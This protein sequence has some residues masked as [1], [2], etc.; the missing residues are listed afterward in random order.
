MIEI[1]GMAAHWIAKEL[2]DDYLWPELAVSAVT[3]AD[4]HDWDEP[5]QTLVKMLLLA[6]ETGNMKGGEVVVHL[7]AALAMSMVRTTSL[8]ASLLQ[9]LMEL[10]WRL[11]R[12][13]AH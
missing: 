12:S 7:F 2:N 1:A 4:S 13:A 6:G 8:A 9:R 11:D 5:V 3:V 10:G